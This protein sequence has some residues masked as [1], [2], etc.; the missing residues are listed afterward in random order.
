M[1]FSLFICLKNLFYQIKMGKNN[2]SKKSS[3]HQNIHVLSPFAKIPNKIVANSEFFLEGIL[4]HRSKFQSLKDGY[5]LE[6]QNQN[7]TR[8]TG[9][10]VT[11]L[12]FRNSP[13]YPEGFLKLHKNIVMTNFLVKQ[14]ILFLQQRTP[15][16]HGKSNF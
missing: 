8:C 7:T 6:D 10:S 11:E 14:V 4:I 9:K 2:N 12:S 15:L 13:V 3:I 5:R 16:H 1:Q